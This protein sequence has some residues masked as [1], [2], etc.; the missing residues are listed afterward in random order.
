MTLRGIPAPLIA[1]AAALAGCNV[2]DQLQAPPLQ[3]PPP[4]GQSVSVTLDPPSA[5]VQANGSVAFTAAVTGSADTSVTWAVVPGS[6]CGSVSSTGLYIAPPAATTCQ[7][8]ATSVA[9]PTRSAAAT[10]TVTTGTPP[11][12]AVTVS[13]ASGNVDACQTLT[14]TATVTG[15]TNRAVTWAVQE[16]GGGTIGAASGV[17]T[18]PDTAGTYHVVATSAADPTQRATASAVV[19]TKVL[20]VTVSPA[21]VSVPP[22]GTTQL[23][24]TVTTS[25]GTFASLQTLH[26]DG[27]IS[28]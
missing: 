14:F 9:D 1:L 2:I 5:A 11:T 13:P 16:A 17:Y 15:T 24:A 12:V 20:G 28:E 23:T 26:A 6:G 8:R 10:V 19:A 22:S 25:C 27:S 7:V 21:M 18:A 3:Q 4:G